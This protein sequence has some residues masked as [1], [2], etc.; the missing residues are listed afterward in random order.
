[1]KLHDAVLLVV[2]Y[3]AAKDYINDYLASL[4]SQIYKKFDVLIANDG[5]HNFEDHFSKKGLNWICIDVKGSISDNRRSLINTAVDK[6]YKHLIFT[7][8][9]DIMADNRIE[10][11]LNLLDD[12]PV[13]VN[14]LDLI[15]KNRNIVEKAYLSHRYSNSDLIGLDS[16]VDGNIMGL[17][18]TA[19][20]SESIKNSPALTS[21]DSIAFDWYLWSSILFE[22]NKAYFTNATKTKYRIYNN[23]TAGLPQKVDKAY[24]IK[25]VKVKFQHYQLMSR[26]DAAYAHY[27]D[28]YGDLYTQ[29]KDE[30]ICED[31]INALQNNSIDHPVWWEN[32]RL[33][34]EV[35]L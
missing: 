9:D 33:P 31:Y 25:G 12:N 20:R 2:I 27:S 6:G 13:L 32:I 21:G 15:D 10:S 14:D 1:M 17:S 16:L 18:N 4:E 24:V 28:M 8:I 3:E 34:T 19:A 5:Y 30:K 11:T 29:L 35:G 7:D 26:L 22:D 23:N